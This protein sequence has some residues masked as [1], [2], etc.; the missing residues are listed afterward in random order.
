VVRT[1]KSSVGSEDDLF[2]VPDENGHKEL[3]KPSMTE[4]RV[5]KRALI[6]V[7]AIAHVLLIGY[8]M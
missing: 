2:R 7:R 8:L 3:E 1:L 4:E 6:I 5:V